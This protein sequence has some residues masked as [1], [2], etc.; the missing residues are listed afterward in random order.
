MKKSILAA[1]ALLV[2]AHTAAGRIPCG[3]KTTLNTGWEYVRCDLS[4][5][6]EAVRPA[7]PGKPE[8]VP[9]W[10]PVA[11]PHCFNATD[12]VAPDVNYYQGPGWY[13]TSIEVKNPFPHGR[14]L[15]EFDGA[16]QKSSVWVYTTPV[17]SH[18]GGYDGWTVDITEAARSFLASPEAERFA[19]R[20]PIVV[21]CDNSRDADLVPSD[22]SDFNVYGGI[23][24]DLKLVYLPEISVSGMAIAPVRSN[25]GWRVPVTIYVENSLG[26]AQ[27]A[28]HVKVK[29][30]DGKA[31]INQSAVSGAVNDRIIFEFTVSAPQ[32][33]DVDSP[34]LYTIEVGV[35]RDAKNLCTAT[36]RFGLRTF[37]FVEKGP[38]MLNGRRVLLQGT[39]RHE[40]HAGLGAALTSDI[41]RREMQ[42]MK[43]MGVNFI[44]LGHYQQSD[45][46]LDL[47]DSL[48][49]VVWEEVP[50]CRGGVGGE[51]YQG[52]VKAMMRN[53][54]AQHRNHPSVILW[55]LGNENDWPGDFE[56]FSQDSIRKFMSEL[57][58]LSHSLDPDRMTSIRRC[59]FANDI[60]DVYSPSLWCGWYSNVFRDFKNSSTAEMNS[61]KRYLHVEWGGD[62]HAGRH[63][64]TP[65]VFPEGKGSIAVRG[66]WDES[67][68]VRLF[69]W[70]LKEQ[71]TMPWLTGTAAWIFK[72]FSTPLRPDNPVPYVNQKGVVTRDL[73]PKESYYVFQ[74][75]W[76]AKPMIHI[77]GHTW[78]VRWGKKDEPKEILVYS[79]AARVELVVN[80]KSQ[81]FRTRDPQDFPAA[82]LRWNVPLKEGKNLI[83]A[84]TPEG[85]KD[86]IEVEY[87]TRQWGA[88]A[89]LEYKLTREGD[90]VTLEVQIVDADGVKCLDAADWIDFKAAGQATLIED[91][92]T[93]WASSRVQAANGR[94]RITA[95]LTGPAALSATSPGLTPLVVTVE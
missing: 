3:E 82:G 22:M 58:D 23:Y 38:F 63:S 54:I 24:R 87:Q 11:L 59:K 62:S 88:P 55:G 49:I 42:M 61:V 76:T 35:G 56:T 13:R 86:R 45:L 92:G 46:C 89:R 37:E 5:P 17:G 57:N 80:G 43:D 53:M 51:P 68:I 29:D 33:W 67:Y 28:Y 79:N 12:A 72:D 31:V 1:L 15:L 40:D 48:G 52:R 2:A 66:G 95:M 36:E 25:A 7:L 73:T 8:I 44:R 69:D 74:S 47:C 50:W 41:V 65:E 14:T 20:V 93:P 71:L 81:G 30:P 9:L 16:G 64:E 27:I 10:T 85:L 18:D 32:L 78:P 19:G 60:P 39:H 6:W 70:H 77:Y 91:Q 34:K 21:R 90:N 4:G 26:A 83:E 94:A 75:Y 84:I